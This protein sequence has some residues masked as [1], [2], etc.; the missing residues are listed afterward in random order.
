MTKLRTMS[1]SDSTRNESEPPSG[2][3]SGGSRNGHADGDGRADDRSGDGEELEHSL[4][5]VH[6][7]Q[8]GDN[9]A[10]EQ[11]FARYFLI[12]R[13]IVRRSM[14]PKLRREL[15]SEDV[16]QEAMVEAIRGLPDFRIPDRE[17]LI[18]LFAA[19]VRNR[20]RTNARRTEAQKRD[21]DREVTLAQLRDSIASGS[22]DFAPAADETLPPD[23]V[24]NAE[25]RLRIQGVLGRLDEQHQEV[26]RL[27]EY[28]SLSWEEVAERMGSPTANAARMLHARAL[29]KL[30]TELDRIEGLDEGA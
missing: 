6:R 7:A 20:M 10:Y 19:I 25:L 15:G 5:L 29:V 8:A 24:A 16:A 22:I 1:D 26:I 30:K 13:Q 11:L 21:R 2:E 12:V 28:E 9:D 3:G 23:A 14:G 17:S 27:R 4:D 18:A